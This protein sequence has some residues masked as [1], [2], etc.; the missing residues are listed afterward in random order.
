MGGVLAK[1]LNLE[2]VIPE[3]KK[4]LRIEVDRSFM[5][6]AHDQI[7]FRLQHYWIPSLQ[8]NVGWN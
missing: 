1:S 8:F 7:S 5:Q 3:L 2:G 4:I 6:D